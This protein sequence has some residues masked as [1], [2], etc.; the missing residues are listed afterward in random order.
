M[1]K[2]YARAEEQ[3][4]LD[5]ASDDCLASY[6]FRQPLPS[7]SSQDSIIV[8]TSS[9][10]RRLQG[11]NSVL[12]S[13]IVS[14]AAVAFLCGCG[15]SEEPVGD[16][17]ITVTYAGEP[18]TIG[19]VNLAGGAH[20]ATMALSESGT[21]LFE[22]ITVGRYK[23]FVFPPELPGPPGIPVDLQGAAAVDIRAAVEASMPKYP[24][25]PTMF[26][27]EMTSPIEIQVKEGMESFTFDLKQLQEQQ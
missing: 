16:V 25:I 15:S 3:Q 8:E 22:D 23:V 1:K 24:N 21:V 14:L 19:S 9:A 17:E 27:T 20:G 4:F 5:R 11:R 2:F 6:K 12:R 18:V 10:I 26:H 7:Y 13:A